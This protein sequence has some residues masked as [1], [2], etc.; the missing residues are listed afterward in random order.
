MA[1]EEFSTALSRLLCA[2]TWFLCSLTASREMYGKSYFSLG[3]AEK[4]AVDGA[5][6]SAIGS[7]LSSL[8]PEWLGV[9]AP[10]KTGFRP[11]KTADQT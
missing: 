7:N 6:L 1:E 2:E 10:K 3:V 9:V 11:E 8:T 5:V 4:Q